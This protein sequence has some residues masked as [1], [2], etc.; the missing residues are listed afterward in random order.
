MTGRPLG[1]PTLLGLPYDAS[2][3]FLKGTAAAPPLIRQALHS[4]AGNPWTETGIDLGADR[5]L[6]D[7]G[8]VPLGSSAADARTK[9]EEAVRTLLESGGR[10][11]VLGGDHSVTYPIVRAVR[12]FHPKLSILH[13]DAHPDLYPEFEGDRYSHACPFAR[14]LEEK[15]VDHVVQVGIRTMNAV[16][17]T[18]AERYGV[19]VIDMRAWVAG[20]RPTLHEPVYLSIDI[21]AFDPAFAPGVSHREPGGLTAREVLTVLQGLTVPIVGADIVEFNPAQDPSGVTAT[22]CAKL[23]KEIAGKMT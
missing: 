6:A 3:S 18:Q 10:P 5:A 9:I 23:V 12:W 19:E 21:D 8:D 22:L 15:L 20:Q 4:P 13:F 16:Q 14:I 17:R 2:S 1:T 7:A 11:I